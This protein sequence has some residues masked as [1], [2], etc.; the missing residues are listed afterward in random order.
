MI[1]IYVFVA[2]VAYNLLCTADKPVKISKMNVDMSM[3]AVVLAYLVE[4]FGDRKQV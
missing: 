4:E 3:M 1:S 2:K